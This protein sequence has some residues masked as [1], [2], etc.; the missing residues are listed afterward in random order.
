VTGLRLARQLKL[1]LV[2]LAGSVAEDPSAQVRREAAIALRFAKTPEAAKVWAK[3]AAKHDGADAWYLAA[4]GIGANLNWD[5]CLDA[6]LAQVGG[7]WDTAGGRDII[8]ISRAQKSGELLA[9]IMD[10]DSLPA[11]DKLRFVR[12]MDFQ[13]S[14]EERQ[15]A[16]KK[17]LQN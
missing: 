1:D 2:S 7:K 15:A 8:W 17:S 11:K 13:G 14:E 6:Y 5:A 9:K 3:L 4:L 16:L 10:S 12:A